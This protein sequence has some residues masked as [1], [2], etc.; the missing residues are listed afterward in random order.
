M[1]LNLENHD[2]SY[3]F[4]RLLAVLE[5]VERLTYDRDEKR[6]PNAIR[7]QSAYVNHPMQTW[8]ILTDQLNPDLQKLHPEAR[9]KYKDMITDIVTALEEKD[10]QQLNRGLEE[11]YLIGY[12]LQRAELNK[13]VDIK[14]G[15]QNTNDHEEAGENEHLT[16]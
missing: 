11:T 4:G 2:R 5:K 6:E 15:K 16:E 7:L 1:K 9:K 10:E 14:T 3:L 8:K 13:R 12:Y